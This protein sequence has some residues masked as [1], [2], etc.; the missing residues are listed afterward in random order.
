[1]LSREDFFLHLLTPLM[2]IVSFVFL[3]KRGMRFGT[4]MLGMLPVLLYGVLYLQKVIRAPEG[5]RWEDFYGF[6]KDG[7]WAR[8]FAIMLAGCFLVCLFYLWLQNL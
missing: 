8:A 6:N 2:A 4:S 3:E 7:K 5:K 1:M